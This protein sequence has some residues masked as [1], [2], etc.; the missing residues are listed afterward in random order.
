MTTGTREGKS[1]QSLIDSESDGKLIKS[2]GHGW[3]FYE[4]VSDIGHIGITDSLAHIDLLEFF[5]LLFNTVKQV[6]KKD[7]QTEINSTV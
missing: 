3:S 7:M 5:F 1:D 6:K 4:C 2:P